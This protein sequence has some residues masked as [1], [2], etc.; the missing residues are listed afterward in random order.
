[1]WYAIIGIDSGRVVINAYHR[2][3]VVME[4]V[5]KDIGSV[6]VQTNVYVHP[7]YAMVIRQ[8]TAKTE[9]MKKNV[10]IVVKMELWFVME[11]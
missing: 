4:S 10:P 11:N 2:K 3:R 9:V 7:M 1:M 8:R 5:E 6:K